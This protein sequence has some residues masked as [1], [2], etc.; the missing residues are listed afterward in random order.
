MAIP[1]LRKSIAKKKEPPSVS[2]EAL[3]HFFGERAY[4]IVMAAIRERRRENW[5]AMVRYYWQALIYVNGL[6]SMVREYSLDPKLRAETQQ[7]MGPFIRILAEMYSVMKNQQ[8]D[9][10]PSN[11][12]KW[13]NR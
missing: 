2:D 11:K 7:R 5:G 3:L 1:H 9:V 4:Q 12:K 10:A 13:G 6:D 8:M